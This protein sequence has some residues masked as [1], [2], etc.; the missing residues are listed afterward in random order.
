LLDVRRILKES[1]PNDAL[2]GFTPD[3]GLPLGFQPT[4][5]AAGEL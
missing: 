1:L 2:Y 4:T 5:S 3:A